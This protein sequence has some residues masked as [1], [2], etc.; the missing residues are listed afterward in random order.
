M[1]AQTDLP[2]SLTDSHIAHLTHTFDGDMNSRI[3]SSQLLVSNLKHIGIY[4]GILAVT[5][6]NISI[7][8]SW[9][10]GQ[11]MVVV[12]ILLYI[13]TFFSF[14]LSW[15]FMSLEFTHEQNIWTRWLRLCSNDNSI[16]VL[17]G[18]GAA[19]II[20]NIL[21]DLAIIWCCWMV[22][23]QHFLIVLPTLCLLTGVVFTLVTTIWCTIAIVYHILHVGRANSGVGGGLGAYYHV[24]E[25]LIESSALYS[26][27]APTILIGW[28]ATASFHTSGSPKSPGL[29]I[30]CPTPGAAAMATNPTPI[31]SQSTSTPSI[32]IGAYRCLC[33]GLPKAHIATTMTTTNETMATMTMWAGVVILHCGAMRQFRGGMLEKESLGEKGW[34]AEDIEKDARMKVRMLVAHNNDD[35]HTLL[36]F[37]PSSH[38][39][40]LTTSILN[41]G[42]S[43][44]EYMSAYKYN[45][46]SIYEMFP[47]KP[48]MYWDPCSGLI[49]TMLAVALLAK[50][51][52]SI[53]SSLRFGQAQMERTD[54][55]DS[56]HV[57]MSTQRVYSDDVEA[58]QDE[59]KIG[60]SATPGPTVVWLCM[61][62]RIR[63]I[64]TTDICTQLQGQ[65]KLPGKVKVIFARMTPDQKS[66][67]GFEFLDL[68]NTRTH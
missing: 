36:T 56:K 13:A 7:S 60:H 4:T 38:H 58:Q 40:G 41:I 1:A 8:K 51:H 9:H 12:I 30:S 57:Q 31:P 26:G 67:R 2:T 46:I 32:N 48:R 18:L 49:S 10:I 43:S 21:S 35:G 66:D 44:G 16:L 3:F 6:W 33:K 29:C 37:N 64:R 23:G 63:G 15:T 61:D 47:I 68:K 50:W 65:L 45:M 17:V 5:M 42:E 14:I 25:V 55:P 19:S 34:R 54:E 11:A 20:C 22:W 62:I 53:M 39:Q 59:V 28:V 27:I 24:I 52:G